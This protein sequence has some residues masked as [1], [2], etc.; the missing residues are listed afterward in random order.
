MIYLVRHG[1]EFHLRL[2]HATIEVIFTSPLFGLLRETPSLRR[3]RAPA[4]GLLASTST[5]L[6]GQ[7]PKP[8]MAEC[9]ILWS[10]S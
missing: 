6:A 1:T 9:G 8:A 7:P 4:D 2:I 5:E 10:N 3:D